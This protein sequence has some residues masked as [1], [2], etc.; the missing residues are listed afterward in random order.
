MIKGIENVP[1]FLYYM[2]SQQHPPK[3]SSVAYL[4]KTNKGYFDHK[5]LSNREQEILMNA[6][7]YYA[8]LEKDGDGTAEAVESR[9]G[10]VAAVKPYLQ[11]QLCNDSNS[12][13]KFPGWW[14][15]YFRSVSKE[16][17]DSVS[18]VKTYVYSIPPYN[19]SEND[20]LIFTIK[21]K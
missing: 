6:V 3:D 11:K 18:L 1:F 13:A 17:Y 21:L 7:I 12:L 4:I 19:K 20:S 5:K 2:Y 14:G 8:N 9:F 15:N 16:K 10:A